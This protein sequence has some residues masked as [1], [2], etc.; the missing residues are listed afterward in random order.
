MTVWDS[1]SGQELN[2]LIV[3]NQWINRV[4]ISP[5]GRRL[6]AAAERAAWVRELPSGQLIRTFPDDTN[7]PIFAAFADDTVEHFA[8]IDLEGR[9]TLWRKGQAPQQLITIRGGLPDPVRRV[10]FSPDGR[11]MAN[12]GDENTA[13]VWDLATGTERL[14]IGERVQWVDFSRD[15][16]RMVTHGMENWV[17]TWDLV[18]ARKLKV[19]RGHVTLVNEARLS[20]DGRLV[21]SAEEQAVSSRSG[22]PG[23]DANWPRIAPGNRPA[24]TARMVA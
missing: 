5:D 8:T 4:A 14:A 1:A 11:W 16:N 12:A 10:F 6:F 17:T 15:G 2:R 23:R 18:Q 9:L 3:T 21:V 7:S 22:A 20:W 24:P 19:L 13:R